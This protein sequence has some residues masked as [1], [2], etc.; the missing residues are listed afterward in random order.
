[1]TRMEVVLFVEKRSL[2]CWRAK[3]LYTLG[4]SYLAKGLYRTSLSISAR[5]A[6]SQPSS[7]SSALAPFDV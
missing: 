4:K 5:S 3:G 7:R 2:R 1:V 6:V